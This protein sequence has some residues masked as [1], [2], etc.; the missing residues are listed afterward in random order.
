V[1]RVV[2]AL[3]ATRAEMCQP[4]AAERI[5]GYMVG[6]QARRRSRWAA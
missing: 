3:H 5:T 6:D 2:S 1:K 4:A